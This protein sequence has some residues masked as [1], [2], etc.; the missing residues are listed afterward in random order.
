MQK[1]LLPILVLILFFLGC[2]QQQNNEVDNNTEGQVAYDYRKLPNRIEI[3]QK[4]A[5]VLDEWEAY[6]E[7][8]RSFE[9]FYQARN[10]EDLKLAVDDLIEKEKAMETSDY[11]E[12][13]DKSQ[14]KSR[15][16]V[17]KTFLLKTRADLSGN[18]DATTSAVATVDAFNA[19]RGQFNVITNNPLDVKTILDEN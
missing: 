9:I 13:F 17:I 7:F 5:A 16:R 1:F 18:R 10:D 3:N 15:Q 11:P 8:S 6:V 14:I 4:A 12:L 19:F 2:G